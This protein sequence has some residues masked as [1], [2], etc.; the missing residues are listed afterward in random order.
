MQMTIPMI[1]MMIINFIYTILAIALAVVAVK[2]VDEKI[3]TKID[4]QDEIKKGN[5][6]AAILLGAMLLFIAMVV[7]SGLKG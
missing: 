1:M 5:M 2:Y 3:F 6:A 4:F 7:S